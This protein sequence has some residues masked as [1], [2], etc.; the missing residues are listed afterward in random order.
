MAYGDGLL[1][2]ERTALSPVVLRNSLEGYPELRIV[3]SVRLFYV[4]TIS[5]SVARAR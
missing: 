2:L 4:V 5:V 1:A 3:F